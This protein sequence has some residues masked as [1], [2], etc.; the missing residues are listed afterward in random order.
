[1]LFSTFVVETGLKKF[2][3]LAFFVCVSRCGGAV[4]SGNIIILIIIIIIIIS[5]IFVSLLILV[6]LVVYWSVLI[7]KLDSWTVLVSS[8]KKP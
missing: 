3:F 6:L 4:E 7:L 5:I 1:M 8:V 2:L